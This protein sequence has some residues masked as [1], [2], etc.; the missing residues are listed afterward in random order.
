MSDYYFIYKD[1]TQDGVIAGIRD[2]TGQA[3]MLPLWT[4]GYWQCRER[5]KKPG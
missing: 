1:G 3:T 5:Y 4:M 2:L